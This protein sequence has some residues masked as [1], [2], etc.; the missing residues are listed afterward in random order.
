MSHQLFYDWDE[1]KLSQLTEPER[2]TLLE[3]LHRIARKGD[4]PQ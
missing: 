2:K 3:L 1:Q 4:E